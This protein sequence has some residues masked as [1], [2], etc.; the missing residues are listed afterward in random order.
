MSVNSIGVQKANSLDDVAVERK[1]AELMVAH[2]AAEQLHDEDF[3]VERVA[4][5]VAVEHVVE[6]FG[7][8]LGVVEEL[9]R[10]EVGWGGVGFA[11]LFLRW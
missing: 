5:V 4:F 2:D 11:L 6:L 8:C 10:G 9:D 7:E 1:H 3:V